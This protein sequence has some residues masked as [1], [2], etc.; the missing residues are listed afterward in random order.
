MRFADIRHQERALSILR[1]S[2]ASGRGH[3]AYLFDGPDGVGKE[4]A[5]RALAAKLLCENV[6][7]QAGFQGGLGLGGGA[8]DDDFEPCGDCRSCRLLA[9]GNHPDFHVIERALHKL[10]SIPT[11]RKS[12]GL[13]LVVDV[14]REF[15]IERASAAPAL[16]KRRVFLI[17]E[18]E[19]MN[20]QAQNALLKTLE[21]P[22]GEAALILITASSSRLLPTIRSRCQRIPFGALPSAFV[23]ERLVAAG[24]QRDAAR[25]L[26]GLSQGQLGPALEWNRLNLAEIVDRVAALLV[27]TPANEPEAF[28]KALVEIA[29]E[30]VQR[31]KAEE[32]KAAKTAAGAPDGDQPED[33]TDDDVDAEDTD[34]EKTSVKNIATDELRGALKLCFAIVSAILRDALVS[35]SLRGCGAGTGDEAGLRLLSPKIAAVDRLAGTADDGQLSG[36][37][38]GVSHAEYMLD[39]NVAP[40]LVCDRLA[41]SLG[42]VHAL[43]GIA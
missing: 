40:A 4:L 20:D 28:S 10:H 27:G 19:R 14:I 24:V 9:T 39:R 1:R 25:T 30:V 15:L 2:L 38:R 43:D 6:P 11:I 22:P 5:G 31:R 42:D 7:G 3:H 18:A 32:K 34:E 23:L 16:G 29:A 33:E 17:R 21:E 35:Q 37:I 26:T 12:K 13:F 36:R 8:A 41:L